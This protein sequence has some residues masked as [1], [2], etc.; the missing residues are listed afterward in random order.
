MNAR[1]ISLWVALVLALLGVSG[2]LWRAHLRQQVRLTRG[3]SLW[4]VRYTVDGTAEKRG[5]RLH[6]AYPMDTA[7]GRVFRQELFHRGLTPARRAAGQRFNR[8]AEFSADRAG[9]LRVTAQFD[10]HVSPA[11]NWRAWGSAG[12]TNPPALPEPVVMATVNSLALH[13][14]APSNQVLALLLLFQPAR[15]RRRDRAGGCRQHVD[16]QGRAAGWAGAGAGGAGAGGAVAGP[17]RCGLRV[18]NR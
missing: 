1:R 17:P 7:Q 12:A 5:A 15:G 18:G 2:A 4:R 6:L 11:S 9:A 13:V 3:D 16:A 8:E 14:M 10:V